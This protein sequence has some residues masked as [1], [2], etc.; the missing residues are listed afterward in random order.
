VPSFQFETVEI[1]LVGIELLKKIELVGEYEG[2]AAAAL[3]PI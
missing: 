3:P 2:G 1:E